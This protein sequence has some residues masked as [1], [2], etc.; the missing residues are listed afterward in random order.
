MIKAPL[1][2]L[3]ALYAP[4]SHIMGWFDL[5]SEA[6]DMAVR[7]LSLAALHKATTPRIHTGREPQQ[8]QQTRHQSGLQGELPNKC[9]QALSV[10]HTSTRYS[11]CKLKEAYTQT[12][13]SLDTTTATI[14]KTNGG[15]RVQFHMCTFLHA[16]ELIAH[17]L[18]LCVPLNNTHRPHL[19]PNVT[20]ICCAADT[21]ASIKAASFRCTP[22]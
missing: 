14:G 4:L 9:I 17:D 19:S 8:E 7:Y 22:S 1:T 13:W 21:G 3:R 16:M 12:H 10:G 5:A 18:C 11:G 2:H 6:S 15:T 20:R